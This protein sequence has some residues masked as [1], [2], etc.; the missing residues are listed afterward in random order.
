MV[1]FIKNF[2]GHAGAIISG[3]KGKAEDK[4]AALEA[5]NVRVTP[6][7]AQLGVYMHEAMQA[8]GL[9]SGGAHTAAFAARLNG[10]G[11]ASTHL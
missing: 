1:C 7:P 5:V 4:V 9:V 8:A 6:S 10:S 11:A 2:I 3:G